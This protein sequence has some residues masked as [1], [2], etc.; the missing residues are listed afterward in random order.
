MPAISPLDDHDLTALLRDISHPPHNAH[1]RTASRARQLYEAAKQ[2]SWNAALDLEWPDPLPMN[3]PPMDEVSDALT[4]FTAFHKLSLAQQ[5]EVRWR[6]H[7]LEINDILHG[8]Q[9]AML[10]AAQLVN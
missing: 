10:L 7:A 1:E 5:T 3:E 8:E 4:G 6:Q 2:R 9:A